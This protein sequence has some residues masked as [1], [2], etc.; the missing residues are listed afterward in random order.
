MALVPERKHDMAEATATS[1]KSKTPKSPAAFAADLPKFAMPKVEMPTAFRDMAESGIV[2]AKDGYE[3]FKAVAEEAT[4][5]LEGAYA[6]AAKGASAYNLLLIEA[7]RANT[8]AAF[9]FAK[10]LVAAKSLS[11]LVELSTAHTRKQFE[12]LSSQSKDLAAL[13]QKVVADSTE[14]IKDGISKAIRKAA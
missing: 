7:A 5:L 14:P 9:D 4:E 6:K 10:G 1:S 12:A 11:E 2:H 8:N 13:A 3:K